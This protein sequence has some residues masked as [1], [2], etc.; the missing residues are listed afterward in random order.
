MHSRS[1][2]FR[3]EARS[4]SSTC[5]PR[6]YGDSTWQDECGRCNFR[7]HVIQGGPL[8]ALEVAQGGVS[9][10]VFRRGYLQR[11]RDL[12]C[13]GERFA[14]I[15]RRESMYVI[16]VVTWMV[17]MSERIPFDPRT[18]LNYQGVSDCDDVILDHMTFQSRMG[19]AF[20]R[21]LEAKRVTCCM[22]SWHDGC[23]ASLQGVCG[24]V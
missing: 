1:N 5:P 19:Q 22:N 17:K 8:Q 3:C 13:A 4:R 21:G 15:S 18:R 7:L 20:S 16:Q 9:L 23:H 14:D 2:R 6:S 10:K 11:R 12:V 24:R